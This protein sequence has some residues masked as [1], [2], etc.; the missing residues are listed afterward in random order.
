ML[1]YAKTGPFADHVWKRSLRAAVDD[2]Y[3][4]LL[5]ILAAK[6]RPIRYRGST[7]LIQL[8][9]K[10]VGDCM[11]LVQLL[12]SFQMADC[13]LSSDPSFDSL[14]KMLGG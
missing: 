11:R 13:Y 1:R 12:V 2:E 14:L 8:G 4:Y 6:V 5:T 9:E 10:G 3:A 7:D